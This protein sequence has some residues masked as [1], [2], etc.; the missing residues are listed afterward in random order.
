MRIVMVSELKEWNLNSSNLEESLGILKDFLIDE[1]TQAVLAE[2][3]IF[4]YETDSISLQKHLVGK[5]DW[6][7]IEVRSN[8]HVPPHFHVILAEY[9][10]S[11]EIKDCN[12]MNWDIPKK[13]EKKIIL[14]YRNWWKEKLIE[15]WNSTRPESCPVGKI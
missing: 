11:Y 13:Y 9:E 12:K 7:K 1:W 6:V 10:W 3:N 14:W 2:D 8:E 5:V 4:W 15:K